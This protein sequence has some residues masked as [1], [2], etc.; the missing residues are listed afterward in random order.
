MPHFSHR[1][2]KQVQTAVSIDKSYMAWALA[3]C[4][5][6]ALSCS[7]PSLQIKVKSD[8]DNNF[9]VV[10][11]GASFKLEHSLNL[12]IQALQLLFPASSDLCTFI[13]FYHNLSAG[14]YNMLP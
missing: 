12:S 9:A 8:I 3:M 14:S 7:C 1:K 5:I 4:L 10:L 11:L 2:R 6:A 13:L